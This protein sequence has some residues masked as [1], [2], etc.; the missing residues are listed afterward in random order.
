MLLHDFP[1]QLCFLDCKL[2]VWIFAIFT[3][4]TCSNTKNIYSQLIY[5]VKIASVK[6]N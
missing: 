5:D 4:N 2:N 1:H 3:Q 6:F